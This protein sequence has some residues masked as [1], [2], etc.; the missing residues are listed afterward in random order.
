MSPKGDLQSFKIKM[1]LKAAK[2]RFERELCSHLKC[3]WHRLLLRSVQGSVFM[4]SLVER[5]E[6]P[7]NIG[8]LFMDMFATVPVEVSTSYF[9]ANNHDSGRG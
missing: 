6:T 5:S 4:A 9:I 2:V 1:S 3:I 8:A 7:M